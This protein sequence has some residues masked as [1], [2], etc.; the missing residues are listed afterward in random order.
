MRRNTINGKDFP[1][2]AMACEMEKRLQVE[3]KVSRYCQQFRKKK[4]IKIKSMI[5]GV[6]I[7]KIY[8][9]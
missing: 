6:I 4:R 3:V 7:G 5:T 8:C 9:A 1:R 2:Y